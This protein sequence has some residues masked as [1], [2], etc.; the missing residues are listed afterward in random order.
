[1]QED[2]LN[3][4]SLKQMDKKSLQIEVHHKQ[5]DF[6][7]PNKPYSEIKC[8]SKQMSNFEWKII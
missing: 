3:L 7:A 1:M 8:K 6:K 4:S 2:K 5:E